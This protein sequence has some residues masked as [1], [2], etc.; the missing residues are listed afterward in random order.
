MFALRTFAASPAG[1]GMSKGANN[2]LKAQQKRG[3]SS[4]EDDGVHRVNWW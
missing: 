2:M 3:M 4:H 1:K